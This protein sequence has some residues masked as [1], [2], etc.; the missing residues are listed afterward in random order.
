MKRE[1]KFKAWIKISGG[2]GKMV[3]PHL[4]M[5]NGV[6][7]LPTNYILLQFTG[8]KDRKGK[9]IYEGDIV[10]AFHKRQYNQIGKVFFEEKRQVLEL[11]LKIIKIF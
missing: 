4:E 8:L 1:I 9:P 5:Y 11:D 7:K 10:R 6:F 3:Y 2:Y